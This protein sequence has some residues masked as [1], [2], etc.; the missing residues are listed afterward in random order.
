[1]ISHHERKRLT[2]AFNRE[3]V[4]GVA[5]IL[6]CIAGLAVVAGLAIVGVQ[7]DATDAT[8]TAANQQLRQ[9]QDKASIAHSK[10][11]YQERQTRLQAASPIVGIEIPSA[12]AA[13]GNPNQKSSLTQRE[14]VP[15]KP[16]NN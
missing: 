13:H 6:K 15:A 9:S 5:V 3:P 2:E 16:L 10:M 1:M 7:T 11:L 14:E 4:M 12:N 8:A